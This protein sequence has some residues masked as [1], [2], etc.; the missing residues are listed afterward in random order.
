MK[1]DEI[2]VFFGKTGKMAYN[3]IGKTGKML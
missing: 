1:M 3:H 2:Y